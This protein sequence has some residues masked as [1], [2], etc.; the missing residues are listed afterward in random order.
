[1]DHA[2]FGMGNRSSGAVLRG[3]LDKNIFVQR[4]SGLRGLVAGVLRRRSAAGK[5]FPEPLAKL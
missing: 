5:W 4:R 1:M 2:A 3:P